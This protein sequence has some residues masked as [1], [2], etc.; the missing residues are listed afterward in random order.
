MGSSKPLSTPCAQATLSSSLATQLAAA[1]IATA[2]QKAKTPLLA[3]GAAL[4]GLAGAGLLAARTNRRRKVLGVA[5][6]KRSGFSMPKKPSGF[7]LP[8]RNGIRRDA[9]KVAGAVNDAAKRADRVGQRISRVAG[10]VQNISETT[11]QA[12]KRM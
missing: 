8:K 11:D 3:G 1:R 4:A 6:P 2:A 5:M 7:S 10:G 9:R 12:V